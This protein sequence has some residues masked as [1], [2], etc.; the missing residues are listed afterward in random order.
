MERIN[1]EM[2]ELKEEISKIWLH[3]SLRGDS[4]EVALRK[5]GFRLASSCPQAGLI[6]PLVEAK[7][8]EFYEN[9]KKYSFRL[10]LRDILKLTKGFRN[11]DLTHYCS[12]EVVSTYLGFLLSAGIIKERGRGIYDLLSPL[13]DNFGGTLEW[14]VAQVFQREFAS[15]ASWGIRLL[16]AEPGGDYDVIAQVEGRICYV[17]VKSS[18][19]KNIYQEMVGEFLS[20]TEELRPNLAIFLADTQLRLEDKIN[21]LF[22]GELTKRGRWPVWIER[23]REGIFSLE[24]EVMVIN[25]KPDLVGNLGSCLR[26]FF[27]YLER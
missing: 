18:P 5:R 9:M 12:P 19:P 16:E 25:S 20:R 26:H 23:L 4:P 2:K 17:E 15:P 7:V 3:L 11:E 6:Y 1:R 27:G 21:K 13:V 24:K 8:D 14:F 10:L 22:K